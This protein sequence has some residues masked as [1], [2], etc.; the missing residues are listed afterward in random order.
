MATRRISSASPYEPAVGFCR[1]LR[2]EDR[3]LV[4]GTA[5]IDEEG[6][7]HAPGNVGQQARRCFEIAQRAV[8]ELGGS[9]AGA[10]RTRMYLT[11]EADWQAVADA[12]SA[13]FGSVRPA[14]TAV[15]VAALLDPA[16]EVEIE[17]EV[18]VRSTPAR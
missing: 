6:R 8:E 17:V 18:D 3:I 7:P 13:F 9:L 1:A 2:V 16:W 4:S 12:H 15:R 11:P 5:P 14:A 10:V